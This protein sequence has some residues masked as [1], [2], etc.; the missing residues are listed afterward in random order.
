[1]L[2]AG[3]VAIAVILGALLLVSPWVGAPS[4]AERARAAIGDEPVLH[5]VT[6][7]VGS[8]GGSF[9]GPVIEID[10]GEVVQHTRETEIWFDE[11]RALK[12]SVER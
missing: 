4:L 6:T 3:A 8:Q 9:L 10:T 11:S 12:K 7:Q 2:R 5:V 1:M